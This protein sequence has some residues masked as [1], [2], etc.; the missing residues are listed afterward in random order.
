MHGWRLRLDPQR[1]LLEVRLGEGCAVAGAQTSD[2]DSLT[3]SGA[4][5]DGPVVFVAGDADPQAILTAY[6]SSG[7]LES[8]PRPAAVALWDAAGLRLVRDCTGLYP[9]FHARRGDEVLALTDARA[10]L[11][12]G[13]VTRELDPVSIA[14]WISGAPLEPEETL[15]ASLRRVPAGHALVGDTG[16]SRLVRTWD[17]PEPGTLPAAAASEFGTL[18]EGALARAL[19][20]GRAAVFLSGGVDSAAV[21]AAAAAASERL[22][23]EPPLALCVDMEGA[24]EGPTQAA[25]ANALGLPTRTAQAR[26]EEGL[27]DRGLER[28][29]SSLWPTA[30]MW[31]PVF[32][33]LAAMAAAEGV[34]VLAD[35]QGGDDL[36]D[37]GLAAGGALWPKPL[38][39]ASWLLAERRYAGSFRTPLRHL[40]RT[41]RPGTLSTTEAPAWL[42]D[43][44]RTEIAAR[45]VARPRTYAEI[46]RADLTDS[47]LA[48]QR[49]ETFDAGMRRGLTHCH[50]LW[51]SELVRLLDGVPPQALVAGGYPK[52]PARAYLRLRIPAVRGAWPRPALATDLLGGLLARDGARLWA[53]TGGSEQLARLGLIEGGTLL[54]G[55]PTSSQWTMMSMEYWLEQGERQ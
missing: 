43:P 15:Y 7:M 11:D 17:P 1:D 41:L 18:L 2:G 32:D 39:L 27:L 37:G 49:E 48:A 54:A 9:L 55:Y 46:R 50:P 26:V 29:A 25:V 47:M 35:G 10:A 23:L 52:S 22:G 53:Q 30:A 44:F 36:V 19:G 34:K 24:R 28:A 21:A 8:S 4:G 42:A 20:G 45:L 5:Q 38:A 31:A 33:G 3:L 51:D 12:E 6:R 40:V 16:G 13:A 14:A